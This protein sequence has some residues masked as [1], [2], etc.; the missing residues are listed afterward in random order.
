VTVSTNSRARVERVL[1]VLREADPAA[2]LVAHESRTGDE[3]AELAERFPELRSGGGGEAPAPVVPDEAV[4]EAVA[5]LMRRFEDEWLDES[6]PALAGRTPRQAAEDP[7]RRDDL[8]RLL[9][10]FPPPGP[11][12]M[13]RDR[14]AAALGVDLGTDEGRPPGAARVPG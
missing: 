13:D 1:T 3:L 14:L 11:Q 2:E 6:I 4:A 8:V 9:R 7:T 12:H 5:G 10:S